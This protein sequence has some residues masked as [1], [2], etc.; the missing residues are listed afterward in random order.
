MSMDGFDSDEVI[1][2]PV[3]DT[4][5][6]LNKIEGILFMHYWR[7]LIDDIE[8]MSFPKYGRLYNFFKEHAPHILIKALL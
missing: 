3:T 7:E 5:E 6:Y 2:I 8:Y 1:K 4:E